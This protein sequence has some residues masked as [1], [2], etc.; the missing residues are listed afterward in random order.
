MS[1]PDRF[2]PAVTRKVLLFTAGVMWLCV[3]TMLLNYS[4]SWLVLE[5]R[6]I[7]IIFSGIGIFLALLIHHFGF[8]KVADKNLKRI[9]LMEEKVSVFSF[10]T[11]KS[12]ILIVGMIT[13]G[14]TLR[15]SA[16]PKHYLAVLYIG[17]GLALILS[18]IR[19]IRFFVKELK[20][21]GNQ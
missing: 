20:I 13:M 6:R 21:N 17:I 15:H 8:L 19:Y 1:G 18:S 14:V 4:Y 9:L 3:G 2:I 16:I 11:W 12:Y 7:I 10:I 5:S